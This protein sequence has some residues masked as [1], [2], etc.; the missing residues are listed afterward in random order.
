MEHLFTL[1]GVVGVIVRGVGSVR[2]KVPTPRRATVVYEVV[3][4]FP[5][6]AQGARRVEGVQTLR[7]QQRLVHDAAQFFPLFPLFPG[8][9]ESSVTCQWLTLSVYR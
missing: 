7:R 4:G 3:D 6:R 2:A 1:S 8:T 5:C 9:E